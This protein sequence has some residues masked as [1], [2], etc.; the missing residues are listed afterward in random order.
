MFAGPGKRDDELELVV[1]EGIEE[2][3]VESLEEIERL[4]AIAMK[5]GQNVRCTVRVNPDGDGAGALRMGGVPSPFG[6]DEGNLTAAIAAIGRSEWLSFTG[7]HIYAGTQ[8][9]DAEHLIALWQRSVAIASRAAEITGIALDTLDLGGGLGIPYF[10][11]DAALDLASLKQGVRELLREIDSD[12]LLQATR[13]VVEPGRFLAGPSGVYLAQVMSTKL[14]HGQRFVV[15]DGGMHHHLAA[16][17][18]LGQVIKRDFPLVHALA[19]GDQP[20]REVVITGPL[21]TPLDTLAS[22]AALP[23]L[24]VGDLVAVL[25]SGA[26][27]LSASPT[28]FLSQPMPAEVLVEDGEATVIRQRGTLADP[29]V[30]LP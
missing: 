13:L 22:G 5:L 24:N 18:N 20:A 16:S 23:E 7:V 17:G 14:S 26:Y 19:V 12:P 27:G 25:Q 28:G 8:I 30:P 9:L 10:A 2:I 29:I 21:C 4:D 1:A 15:L 11:G 3:H 6:F